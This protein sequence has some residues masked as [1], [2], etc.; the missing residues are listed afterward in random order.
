MKARLKPLSE[1][2]IVITGASSGIGLATARRAAERGAQLVLAARNEE[3]LRLARDRLEALG[4]RVEYVVADV[5]DRDQI[6]EI[7]A[8]AQRAF[9]GFDT[10]INDAAAATYGLIVE[11]PVEDMRRIFEVNFWGMVYGS[12]EAIEHLKG[13]DGG[14]KLINVG[15]VLSDFS[16]PEQGAY[17]ASK[18]AVK[19]FTDALRMEL[20]RAKTPVS[21]TL[22]KPSGIATPYKDHA[23]NYMD[24]P[25]RVPAPLYGPNV[26]ADAILYACEHNIR[27][28]TVGAAGRQMELFEKLLPGLADRLYAAVGPG[29]QKDLRPGQHVE[30]EG[31]LYEPMEDGE[32]RTDNRFVRNFSL[33]TAAQTHPRTTAAL[34]LLAGV[35]GAAAF[36]RGR[37]H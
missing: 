14:G 32:E 13:K 11:T 16:V 12:L 21:V 5:S 4:A 3:A 10:W 30:R 19:G 23:R 36:T 28:L 26:V 20:M 8:Q 15:S 18:H 1:Q 7:A 24:D 6:R 33:Y 17:A 25:A 2:T 34:A 22:I 27:D 37:R 29:L 35:A 9:G 31:N